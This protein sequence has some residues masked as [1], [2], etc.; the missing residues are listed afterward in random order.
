MRGGWDRVGLRGRADLH[1]SE[2]HYRKAVGS[3]NPTW[4]I[5][6]RIDLHHVSPFA[7]AKLEEASGTL[8]VSGT[9]VDRLGGATLGGRL[10]L[11][12]ARVH[13]R[14]LSNI[15][16]DW[17]LVRSADGAGRL[18]ISET[19]AT[20]YGGALT[21][22]AEM[23]LTPDKTDY[24]LTA[25]AYGVQIAPWLQAGRTG[26]LESSIPSGGE[27]ATQIR[28]TAD[29]QLY[30]S[31]V[32]GD[33]LSRRGGGRLEIRDGYIYRVPIL[34]AILNVLNMSVPND[35]ALQE[36]E[37]DY[38]VMGNRLN[39]EAIA[40]RGGSLNLVGSGSMS[41]PDQAVDLRL[42]NAGTRTWARVPLLTDLVEGAAKEL[43]ELRVTGPVSRPTV[44]AQ[45]FRGLTDEFKRLFQK[46]PA[47]K[48]VRE[49]S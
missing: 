36:F 18:L 20:M 25:M 47:K 10:H 48:I 22:Q 24:D 5:A 46:K 19:H 40:L 39:F 41:L 3:L 32:I 26:L 27:A 4:Q 45:P 34:L 7:D 42:V 13:S 44:R 12:T 16:S 2:L 8:T 31:G 17:S 38:F 15:E 43:V 11:A 29:A 49:G 33:P 23:L 37:A 9:L 28:G 14:T 21:G 35:D 30:L 6:G 1:L